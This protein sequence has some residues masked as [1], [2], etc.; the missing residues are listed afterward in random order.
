MPQ[1]NTL[2]TPQIDDT[3]KKLVKELELLPDLVERIS[4]KV[5]EQYATNFTPRFIRQYLKDKLKIKIP[6]NRG[7]PFT[8]Q[9]DNSIKELMKELS[10]SSN[11]YAQIIEKINQQYNTHY[12][13]KQIR[14]RWISKLDADLCLNPLDDEEKSFIIQWVESTQR[15]DRINWKKLIPLMKTKFHKLRSENMVK[16][17]WNLRKR[18]IIKSKVESGNPR[19]RS[20]RNPK[21]KAKDEQQPQIKVEFKNRHYQTERTITHL[22]R[23]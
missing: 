2:I 4:E 14:Q 20:K 5:N 6:Q 22:L 19:K 16:N 18:S 17:Y 9:I 15:G 13:S 11:P 3:I 23:T 21:S 10:Y 8:E 12:T 1:N 7:E